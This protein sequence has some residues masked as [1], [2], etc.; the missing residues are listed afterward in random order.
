MFWVLAHGFFSI[1]A[2]LSFEQK[3]N[4]PLDFFLWG[5]RKDK[6]YGTKPAKVCELRARK[7]QMKWF[8]MLGIPL[9]CI[10]SSA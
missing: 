1:K 9:L 2:R 10:N 5:Y 3:K 6:A 7:Y 8:L 4:Y